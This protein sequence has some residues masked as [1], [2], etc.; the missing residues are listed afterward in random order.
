MEGKSRRVNGEE[1]TSSA[2][3]A[4]FLGDPNLLV[5]FLLTY[6]IST[7]LYLHHFANKGPSSQSYGFSS[8]HIWM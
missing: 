4:A 8:S 7:S 1:F 5:P 6:F 3:M 2:H